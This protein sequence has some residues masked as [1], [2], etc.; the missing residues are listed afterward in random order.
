MFFNVASVLIGVYVLGAHMIVGAVALLLIRRRTHFPMNLLKRLVMVFGGIC[1]LTFQLYATMAPQIL[2]SMKVWSYSWSGYAPFS[3]E[4][5]QRL[6]QGIF[7]RFGPG[8]LIVA[9][10]ILIIAGAGFAV[11]FQRQW[12]L[13]LALTLPLILT[14][15]SLGASGL[16]FPARFF[17]LALP[18]AIIAAVGGIFWL[19]ELVTRGMGNRAR[20]F[21]SSAAMALVVVLSL[22]SLASLRHYYAIPKQPF[23]TSIE[24]IQAH[25]TAGDIVIVSSMAD[26]GIRYYSERYGLL[27][28]RDYFIVSSAADVDEVLSAHGGMRSLFVTTY[29]RL[30]HLI[31]P[32]LETRVSNGWMP[33]RTFRGTLTGGDI[34]VWKER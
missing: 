16:V 19:S 3:G 11:L 9:V 34:T 5:L 22:A 27:E 21:S 12:A 7:G 8:V 20:D 13:M 1:L 26:V 24:Y 32:N 17:V 25:R 18:L 23:R 30:F 10:P 31:Y 29:P 2:F 14:A 15:V 33:I 4:V 6:L 28:G